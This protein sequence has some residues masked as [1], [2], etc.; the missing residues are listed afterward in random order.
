MGDGISLMNTFNQPLVFQR[1]SFILNAVKQQVLVKD[2][3][4][5]Q[6]SHITVL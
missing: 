3:L 4:G 2:C 5:F 6:L 1:Q